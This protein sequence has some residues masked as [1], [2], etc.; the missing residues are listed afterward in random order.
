M[1][2]MGK[3]CKVYPLERL[4]MWAGWD[5]KVNKQ[6]PIKEVQGDDKL[7][8]YVFVQENY[9][10]TAGVALDQEILFDDVTPAWK[11]FCENSL[12]FQLPTPFTGGK[13][14]TVESSEVAPTDRAVPAG[15]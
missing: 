4:K 15:S 12:E 7:I 5:D 10:V 11:E 6:V 8:P 13:A 14:F 3:Y 9:T 1:P 2:V